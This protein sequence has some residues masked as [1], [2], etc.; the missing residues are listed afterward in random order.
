VVVGF[1]GTLSCFVPYVL[2]LPLARA[3]ARIVGAHCRVGHVTRVASRKPKGTVVRE[4]PWPG[5][6]VKRGTEVRLEVAL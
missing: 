2:H 3:K 1:G 4:W 6:V 5:K